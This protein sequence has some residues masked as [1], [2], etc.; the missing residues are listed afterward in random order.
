MISDLACCQNMERELAPDLLPPVAWNEK[1]RLLTKLVQP[2]TPVEVC[3]AILV[4]CF[5]ASE[6]AS[7]ILDCSRC[8][9]SNSYHDLV[10]KSTCMRACPV[11]IALAPCRHQPLG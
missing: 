5:Q 11:R 6:R 1:Q 10:C 9:I 7:V 3:A 8:T 2:V 4:S